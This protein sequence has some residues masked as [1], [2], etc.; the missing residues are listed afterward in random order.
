MNT[1]N[2]KDKCWTLVSFLISFQLN[3]WEH[4]V[5]NVVVDAI[6]Q[7]IQEKEKKCNI[8]LWGNMQS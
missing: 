5:Q 8:L 7:E 6:L 4:C 1:D 3:I 2:D